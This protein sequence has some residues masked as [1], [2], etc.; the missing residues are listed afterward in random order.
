M[1]H[2]S[3]DGLI[4]PVLAICARESLPRVRLEDNP[5][6]LPEERYTRRG[7]KLRFSPVNEYRTNKRIAA[8]RAHSFTTHL[9]WVQ[10]F[11]A[12][13]AIRWQRCGQTQ[14]RKTWPRSVYQLVVRHSA[15]LR[16]ALRACWPE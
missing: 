4:L 3:K 16:G 1:P 14:K 9:R 13:K 15:A 7:H 12:P 2:C 10:V 11:V 8:G 6:R 5:R